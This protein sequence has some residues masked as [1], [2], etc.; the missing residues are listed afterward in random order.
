MILWKQIMNYQIALAFATEKHKDTPDR[1]GGAKYI[2][3]PVAVSELLR[4]KGFG[5]DVQIMGLFHDLLEDTDVTDDEI[6]AV[7]NGEV[8]EVVTLVSKEEN[9]LME[10]Y[11]KRITDNEKAS[12]VKVADRIHNLQCA[13]VA[14]EAWRNE[15]YLESLDYF[16]DLAEKSFNID[17]KEGQVFKIDFI[18]AL[19]TLYDT[20]SVDYFN[21]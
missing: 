3:H 15:Y 6:L 16:C 1:K 18:N 21:L 19:D 20:F 14:D 12:A 8:L 13:V 2:T 10:N 5:V 7:S 17:G 9:Y 11:M 4:E